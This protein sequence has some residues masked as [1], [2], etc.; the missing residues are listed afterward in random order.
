MGVDQF[1]KRGTSGTT[2]ASLC[3]GSQNSDLFVDQGWTK[4][5]TSQFS[6]PR[7]PGPAV[8]PMGYNSR[9]EQAGRKKPSLPEGREGKG[10]G[11]EVPG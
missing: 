3:F 2:A 11:T 10:P 1:K 4:N 8:L 6:S 9:L 5:G 7:C